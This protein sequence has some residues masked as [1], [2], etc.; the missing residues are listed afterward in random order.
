MFHNLLEDLITYSTIHQNHY[1]VSQIAPEFQ[2][3][4]QFKPQK[5]YKIYVSPYTLSKS[6]TTVLQH[7]S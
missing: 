2:K 7:F 4:V 1:I 6:Y 3:L 5:I